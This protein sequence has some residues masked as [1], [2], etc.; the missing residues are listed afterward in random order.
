M[1][2]VKIGLFITLD[3]SQRDLVA[4]FLGQ[5]I[6]YRSMNMLEIF[7]PILSWHHQPQSE[8]MFTRILLIGLKLFSMWFTEFPSCFCRILAS[9]GKCWEFRGSAV[10]HPLHYKTQIW[11]PFFQEG[12]FRTADI[13]SFKT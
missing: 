12:G 3:E 10:L 11:G 9:K 5:K 4:T 13:Y 2:I 1:V 8:S 6:M 7:K